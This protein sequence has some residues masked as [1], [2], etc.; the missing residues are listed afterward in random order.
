MTPTL[1]ELRAVYTSP[2]GTRC[3]CDLGLVTIDPATRRV[4]EWR[5]V[6]ADGSKWKVRVTALGVLEVVADP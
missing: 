6:A 5:M 1:A 4:H 2:A 3:V